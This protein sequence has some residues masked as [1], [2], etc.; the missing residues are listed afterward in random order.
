MPSFSPGATGTD[1]VLFRRL[2]AVGQ[3]RLNRP[4]AIN[5]LSLAMVEA[6][7]QQL[8]AWTDDDQVRSV[9]IDG[10]GER[11]LCAGGDV[12]AVREEVLSTGA[13]GPFFETEYRMNL[14][15]S[16]YP[17]PIVSAM[18]GITMG[19]GIG[20]GGH[21]ELRLVTE[22]S[23]LAMP[24]TVIGF[25]PDVGARW[26]LSRAPGEFGTWLAL[27]GNAIDGADAIALG[28][29]DTLVREDTLNEIVDGLANE[30]PVGDDVGNPAPRAGLRN[31]RGWIDECFAGD[32]PEQIC[33]RLEAH[34]DPAARET[35]RT[36][37]ARSPFAV[38]VSLAAL[39]KAERAESLDEVLTDD[40]K[41]AHAMTAHPDFAEGVRAQLVDKDRNPRWADAS[42]AAVD[43]EQVAAVV[44]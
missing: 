16:S 10:A 44:G 14:L 33:A 7:E 24:E 17:K 12:R 28:L 19:G 36:L 43:A 20:V 21:A 6:I 32:D 40:L 15:I 38:A 4:K 29:A 35:A 42:L 1:E 31:H 39:R 13:P 25:F 30:T 26:L 8:L 3:I 11:G 2:G 34:D 5:S 18:H 22:T 9:Y 41:I 23:Q 37:R 27:T